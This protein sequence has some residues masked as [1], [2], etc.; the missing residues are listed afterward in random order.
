[1]I[2]IRQ[3]QAGEEIQLWDIFFTT[4]RNINI[5]DY[6]VEQVQA[7]APDDYQQIEWTKRIQKINPYV[8]LIEN[9]VVGYADVQKDGYVDHFF[10]HWQ[11]QGQGVGRLLMQTLFKKAEQQ[12]LK[13]LYSQVS[14][15]ARPF[16]E[17]FGFTVIKEQQVT[18]RGQ[19][20]TNF[21]M[22]KLA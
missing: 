4:I 22:E 12:Q 1:M 15:T 8:A 18:I 20:L 3:Y 21:V 10:C 5:K 19:I 13:R 6:S 11:C 14:I 17:Y 7:W 16:F 2:E 9:K